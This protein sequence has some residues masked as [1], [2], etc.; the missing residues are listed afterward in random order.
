MARIGYTGFRFRETRGGTPDRL[1][2]LFM[3]GQGGV[4][5]HIGKGR[6]AMMTEADAALPVSERARL[7]GMRKGVEIAEF[8]SETIRAA[9]VGAATVSQASKIEPPEMIDDH[10]LS[11]KV[12]KGVVAGS[13]LDGRAI[14]KEINEQNPGRKFRVPTESELL[15]LNEL[16]GNRLEGTGYWIWTE[17]EHENYPGRFVLRHLDFVYRFNDYPEFRS[18]GS[19]VRLVEDS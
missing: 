8:G 5:L 10:R 18:D 16:L 13:L 4:R 19:A 12:A 1:S 11:F 9:E 15:E 14:A 17:T 6:Y 3:R 2:A 7:V